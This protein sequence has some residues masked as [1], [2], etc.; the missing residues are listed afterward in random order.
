MRPL[1]RSL[2][3]SVL[4]PANLIVAAIAV[5]GVLAFSV[6]GDLRLVS[7]EIDPDLRR[8][9]AGEA[10]DAPDPSKRGTLTVKVTRAQD[11]SGSIQVLVF[12][13]GP[14]TDGA[15]VVARKSLP[16]SPEGSTAVFE[17][18]P[19]GGY[20]VLAHHDANGNGKLDMKQP[21]GPPAEEIG[22]SG[23]RGPAAGPP[24]WDDARIVLDR[25][26]LEIEI[27]LHSY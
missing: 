3:G 18:L 8:P 16:A 5:F 26:A 6:E 27:P 14:L 23:S 4:L 22:S 21:G 10:A 7:K 15:H 13:Q 25:E 19:Y 2:V 17:G 11:A 12:D 20:A 1:D 9:P 24:T